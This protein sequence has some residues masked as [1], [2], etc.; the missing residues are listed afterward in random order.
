MNGRFGAGWPT[1][2]WEDTT[3]KANILAVKVRNRPVAAATLWQFCSFG[4]CRKVSGFE[5][6]QAFA[7]CRRRSCQPNLMGS[8]WHL[9]RCM[10]GI[11]ARR[12]LPRSGNV[13]VGECDEEANRVG[14]H[15]APSSNRIQRNLNRIF[16]RTSAPYQ[17]RLWFD[18]AAD[19]YWAAALKVP[20]MQ[21]FCSNIAGRQ[22][23]RPYKRTRMLPRPFCSDT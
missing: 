6:V 8:T 3:R 2:R 1:V 9:P 19:K 15:R 4:R 14:S 13:I 7:L 21:R 17:R 22:L 10:E 18:T 20:W 12:V 11:L 23:I 16:E 5:E